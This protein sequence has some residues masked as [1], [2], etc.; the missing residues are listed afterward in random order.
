MPD[1]RVVLILQLIVLNNVPQS[2]RKCDELGVLCVLCVAGLAGLQGGGF[3]CC[4]GG[5]SERLG[6]VMGV[7]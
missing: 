6:V 4:C 5:F 2:E 3:C 7:C 1:P